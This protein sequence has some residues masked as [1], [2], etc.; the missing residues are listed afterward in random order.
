MSAGRFEHGTLHETGRGWGHRSLYWWRG[1]HL[2][3]LL[4]GIAAGGLLL[5][6]SL[7]VLLVGVGV[8]VLLLLHVWGLRGA[9]VKLEAQTF[10]QQQ[11]QSV[12]LHTLP[13]L[14]DKQGSA[15]REGKSRMHFV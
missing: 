11:Q 4:L 14:H 2:S 8:A 10:R 15:R 9:E 12:I 3:L 7:S 13:C 5:S 1:R 6:G